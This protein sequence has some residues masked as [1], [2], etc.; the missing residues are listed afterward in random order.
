MSTAPDRKLFG[1]DG[2]RGRPGVF[3]LDDDTVETL[4][5]FLAGVLARDRG[6][7]RPAVVVGWDG[8]E[9]GPRLVSALAAGVRRGGGE[10]RFAGLVPTPA[11]AFLTRSLEAD[12]GISVSASHNPFHDNGIKIFSASGE[13]LPDAEEAEIE[14]HL[15]A[16]DRPDG[17]LPAI[18]GPPEPELR[19]AEAYADFLSRGEPRL[20]GLTVVVDAANGASSL[21]APAVF[22][23]LGA[24][25]VADGVSPDGRNINDGVG[26]LHP[27][28]LAK[29]VVAEGADLGIALDGDADRIIVADSRG[30]IWDGDDLLHLLAVERLRE[31][32]L[33][34]RVVVATVMSNFALEAAMGRLGVELIRTPVGDRHVWAAM[35]RHDARLGGEQ[36][37]HI[38]FRPRA[39][40]GDGLLTGIEVARILAR[41]GRP[42]RELGP[43]DKLPQ[44]LK[45]V[46]VRDRV[47]IDQ[48]APLSAEIERARARLEG[49]GRVLVRYSGTEPLLRI[50][51]EGEHPEEIEAVL[52]ALVDRVSESLGNLEP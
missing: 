28:R 33:E 5:F 31:G 29:R 18:G 35:K 17:G 30:T 11:V 12:A 24:R 41:L 21:L 51:V 15:L 3:P 26:A 9:S 19:L 42:L 27:P 49:H 14:D 48:V 23:R 16:G 36:S 47:P 32:T 39:T 1:T 6:V 38:I 50:M 40:T 22:E 13:K 45:N 46:R 4:G 25:V 37:G 20:D 44:I 43:L 10:I 52:T 34:P 8:R 2:V 7:G